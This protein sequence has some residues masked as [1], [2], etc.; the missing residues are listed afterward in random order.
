MVMMALLPLGASCKKG[1]AALPPEC[2]DDELLFDA[3]GTLAARDLARL[4]VKDRVVVSDDGSGGFQSTRLGIVTATFFD[5]TGVDS[6]PAPALGLPGTMACVGLNGIPVQTGDPT[7][8][9]V[10][11]VGVTGGTLAMP[12]DL[13]PVT[14]GPGLWGGMPTPGGIFGDTELDLVFDVASPAGMTDFPA[15]IENLVTPLAPVVITPDLSTL[16]T[17]GSEDL[18][19][20]WEHAENSQDIIEISVHPNLAPGDD[21]VWELLCYTRDDGC[22]VVPAE[23]LAWASSIDANDFT[24]ELTRHRLQVTDIGANEGDQVVVTLMSG[25]LMTPAVP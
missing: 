2:T 18:V 20:Q 7:P 17:F 19:V 4:T 8:L 15:F 13:P 1:P 21:R 9:G 16:V 14:G 12:L 23:A 25:S 11:S 3:F 10:T 5:I 22:H 24:F 6:Q